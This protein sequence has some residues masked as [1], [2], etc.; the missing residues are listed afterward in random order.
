M[1]GK[2]GLRG[3]KIG[4]G[5]IAIT[6]CALPEFA[7]ICIAILPCQ[8]DRKGDFLIDEIIAGIFAHRAAANAIIHRIIHDLECQPKLQPVIMH[9]RNISIICA[10][11]L[12]TCG[13]GG[14]E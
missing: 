7:V 2:N 11:Q 13:G 1:A 12:G 5:K 6:H 9:H 14:G 3:G 8:N 10:C 4:I